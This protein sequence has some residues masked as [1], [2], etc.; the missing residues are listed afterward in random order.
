MPSRRSTKLAIPHPNELSCRIV[1]IL[2]QL[3]PEALTRGRKIALEQILHGTLGHKDYLFQKTLA[4][5][6]PLDSIRFDFRGNHETGGVWKQGGS[7][8]KPSSSG[9]DT[10]KAVAIRGV[11]SRVPMDSNF[12]RRERTLQLR[13]RVRR[14]RMEKIVGQSACLILVIAVLISFVRVRAGQR[15]IEGFAKQGYYEWNERWQTTHPRQDYPNDLKEFIAWDTSF[16]W[17]DFPQHTDVLTVHG[18]QDH[19]V[20]PYDAVIYTK[21]LSNRHP[22]TATLHFIENGDHNFTGERKKWSGHPAM[23]GSE[24]E[25]ESQSP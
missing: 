7:E 25:G 15:W 16:V 4:A 17:N 24:A 8:C 23:V 20:P 5:Q 13:Q 1:G 12:G 11:P 10:L 3:E 21:A 14:Y 6:L 9:A 2:E 18:L 19:T 22:G